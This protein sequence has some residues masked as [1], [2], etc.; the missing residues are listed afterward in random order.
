MQKLCLCKQTKVKLDSTT[1]SSDKF[2]TA[3]NFVI[4]KISFDLG[5]IK[6]RHTRVK[7]C[8]SVAALLLA[9]KSQMPHMPKR[10]VYA[11]LKNNKAVCAGRLVPQAP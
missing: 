1:K 7:K 2:V 4:N 3:Q 6:H 11:W 5:S 9:Q 10:V 8:T